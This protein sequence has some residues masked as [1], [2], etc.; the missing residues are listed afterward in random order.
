MPRPSKDI[1]AVTSTES[2]TT[3]RS[4]RPTYTRIIQNFYLICLDANIDEI[5]DNDWRDNI[6]RLPR[7]INNIHTFVDTD[8]CIQFINNIKDEIVFLIVTGYVGQQLIPII[9]NMT[10]LH[11]IYIVCGNISRHEQWAKQWIKIRGVFTDISSICNALKPTAQQYDQDSISIGFVSASDNL[12]TQ[13]LDQL[14]PSFMYTQ[15]L[16]QILLNMN[17][18]QSHIQQFI[19]YCQENIKH[20]AVGRSI[21]DELEKKYPQPTPIWWYTYESFLYSM[22]NQ[23]LRE[24]DVDIIIKMGFYVSDLHRQIEQLH[25]KQFDTHQQ[26]KPFIVYRGQGLSTNDF[27]RMVKMKG[28]LISFNNF[29]ST[30]TDINFPL[31]RAQEALTKPNMV[32]VLFV[33]TIDPSISS[34]PFAFIKDFSWAP[35]ENEILFSM[36]AIFRIAQIEPMESDNRLSKVT[37]TLTSDNN[38]KRLELTQRM[39]EETQGYTGLYQ[40]AKLLIKIAKFD[41]A[42]QLLELL[43]TQT[44]DPTEE[45]LIYD[46]LGCTL[47]GQGKYSEALSFYK[48]GLAIEEEALPENHPDLA[49]SYSN[50]GQVYSNMGEY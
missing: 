36:H 41:K 8:K 39:L 19:H 10:Q 30:S 16:K 24:M 45:S 49:T 38:Q 32:G 20:D 48:K 3:T 22:L 50:I 44:S 11:S 21:I 17:F 25:E 7:S 40:L 33:I 9:H 14:D 28:G 6:S 4:T 15:M 46:L 35:N 31:D 18:D 12:S 26:L 34:T 2:N 43:L 5:N 47:S 42:Q 29:L 1:T 23:A 27:N 13:N 37:L